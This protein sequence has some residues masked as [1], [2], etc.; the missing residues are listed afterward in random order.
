MEVLDIKIHPTKKKQLEAKD[1]YR[2]VD[3][4]ELSFQFNEYIKWY[5]NLQTI[6]L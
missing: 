3:D 4:N 2:L 1:I 5:E 6:L